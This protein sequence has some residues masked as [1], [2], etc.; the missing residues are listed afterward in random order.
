MHL[1]IDIQ[2][3]EVGIIHPIPYRTMSY[4]G[5]IAVDIGTGVTVART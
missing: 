4:V 3:M 1:T 5:L 2:A